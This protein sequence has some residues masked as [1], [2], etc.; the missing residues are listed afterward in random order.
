MKEEEIDKLAREADLIFIKYY[1]QQVLSTKSDRATVIKIDLSKEVTIKQCALLCGVLPTT[2][3]NWIKNGKVAS[4][5]VNELNNIELVTL[6]SLS[7]KQYI[8]YEQIDD[9]MIS[10]NLFQ[11][12]DV[13]DFANFIKKS[14]TLVKRWVKER[15][16]DH[17]IIPELNNLILID[18][19]NYTYE[20][21]LNGRPLTE[22]QKAKGQTKPPTFQ[23]PGL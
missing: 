20:F 4:R 13:K 5:K 22:A 12:M 1:N 3:K 15:K 7:P 8:N 21:S 6:S 10:I 18:I 23:L 9:N 16:L 19:D 2:V 17:K 14:Q 11:Y